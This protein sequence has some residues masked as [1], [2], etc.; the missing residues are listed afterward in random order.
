VDTETVAV[1]GNGTYT[2][3]HG[4]VPSAATGA[5]TYQWVASYGGDANNR[6]AASAPGDEPVAATPASPAITTAAGPAVVVGSGVPLT[7]SAT[8]SG[9][10]S[11]TGTIT[12]TLTGPGGGVVDTETVAVNGNGTYST[13][14]G[15][16]PTA[17]T[18]AG[19]YQW[20][21]SYGGD[22]NNNPVASTPG[23]EPEAADPASPAIATTAGG[24][25]VVGSGARLTDSA[26]LSGGFSPTG[27]ITFT[28]TGPNGA[29]VDTEVVTVSGNGTYG[30]PRGFV[31][32]A[33]T[34]AGTYQWVASYSGDVNNRTAASTP[35]SEPEAADP[36]SPAITTTAGGSVVL[37]KGVPLTDSATLSGGF[38]PTGTITFTLIAPGGGVVDTEV[39]TVTGNGTYSTP[40]GFVPATAG[41]YQW[42]ASY[43]GDANNNP[44][45][46]TPGSEPETVLPAGRGIVSK[47]LFLVSTLTGHHGPKHGRRP[48]R[49]HGGKR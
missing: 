8:L 30:T 7:D 10:F 48:A 21:A 6:T 12:F 27:T 38:S 22:A 28:L 40:H 11:P 33:A 23:S 26:T 15:F 32:T 49:H 36:A 35:G 5:G 19:T 47:R 31:P 34:G 1:N 17:A 42:V 14:H 39:V 4:F 18:G 25:V 3:P 45:A 13:P 43:G 20:V 37:G 9:G 24:P 29:T 16:V 2:T 46:S 44:A 41:T